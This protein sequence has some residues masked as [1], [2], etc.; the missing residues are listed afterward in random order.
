M[1]LQKFILHYCEELDVIN[2]NNFIVKRIVFPT[3]Q[4]E[5]HRDDLLSKGFEIF[6]IAHN[7]IEAMLT[8]DNLQLW[9]M[10]RELDK[11]G[12]VWRETG[13]VSFNLSS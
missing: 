9:K 12:W 6:T 4:S 2:L 3:D 1:T 10:I 8:G 11:E 7:S 13:K 5:F